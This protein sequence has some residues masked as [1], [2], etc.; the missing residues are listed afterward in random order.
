[1]RVAYVR[2]STL[3][4]NTDRQ[5]IPDVERTFTDKA[6]GADTDRPALADLI[7]FVR[8]GDTV[9]VWSIDRL[10]RSLK[11]LQDLIARFNAKGVTVEFVSERLTFSADKDDPFARLQFQM[12][13]AFAEFER[14]LIRKR[15]RE[16]IAKAK[17]KGVYKG[18]APSIPRDVILDRLAQGDSPTAIARD[19]S[20]AR[21]SVY[22]I[23]RE[24]MGD[25]LPSIRDK[26][27]KASA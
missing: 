2:V 14:A 18:R 21:V 13:G 7:A 12:M 16:G 5:S 11:D 6:S 4:Q 1:M 3:D 20:I 8:E 22:R 26:V 15:Q 27:A 10:A 23:A 17:D 25:A 19:L 9:C 24:A